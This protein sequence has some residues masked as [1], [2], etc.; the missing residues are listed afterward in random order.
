MKR[1][2]AALFLLLSLLTSLFSS[3][4]FAQQPILAVPILVTNSSFLNVRSG[5]GPQ[6]TILLTVV[7]GTELQVLGSNRSKTWYLVTTPIGPGWVDLSYTIPRGDFSIVPVLEP[8][9]SATMSLLPPPLSIGLPGSVPVVSPATTSTASNFNATST[10][11]RAVLNVVS[12]N[13]RTQPTD[14]A[15][16]I[17]T[18]FQNSTI[19]YEIV[20]QAHDEHNVPWIAIV[21][22]GIGTG[23][24]EAPKVTTRLSGAYATV[25]FVNV[26]SIDLLAAP[27]SASLRLP[28]LS[29]G[30]EIFIIGTSAD[31]HSYQ[32]QLANGITG[33]LPM[34]KVTI[35]Q[36]TPSDGTFTPGA[37]SAAA[38][39]AYGPP[40]PTSAIPIPVLE[41]AHIIVNTSFQNV[42]SGPGSQY[43]VIATV[44]GGESFVPLGVT[45]DVSWY[46]IRGDFGQGWISS[47]YVLFRGTFSNVPIIY[48]AY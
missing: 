36:G 42:R 19:D 7:G 28:T 41:A 25:G 30:Q 39:A 6:Y 44:S 31:G 26:S 1:R 16:A 35:R 20:G 15:A 47:E 9:V 10:H 48:Q 4:A 32:V 33:Y 8:T 13:V 2:S 17:T 38:G 3:T 34:D 11:T 5:D 37:S 22:P 45:K 18:I 27:G 29:Q 43:T 23:W 21:V 40:N 24:I 46:L 12:V 14:A